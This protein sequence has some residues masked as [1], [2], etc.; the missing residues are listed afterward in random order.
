[1]TLDGIKVASV[2]GHF[3]YEYIASPQTFLP[4]SSKAQT[5]YVINE[6]LIIDLF[7]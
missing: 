5:R 2:N 3:N 7:N 4:F 6:I 1:M